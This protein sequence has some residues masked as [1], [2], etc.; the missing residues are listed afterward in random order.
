MELHRAIM[1]LTWNDNG[2]I[3]SDNG[4][5]LK[6]MKLYRAIT[7]RTWGVN[8]AILSDNGANSEQ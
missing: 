5:S 3:P 7:E 8:G 6:L 4:A 1:E 2:I